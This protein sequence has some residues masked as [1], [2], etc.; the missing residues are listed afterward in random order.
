MCSYILNKLRS[1]KHLPL[2]TMLCLRSGKNSIL[3]SCWKG[4]YQDIPVWFGS[5]S[6]FIVS[7]STG[8]LT[9]TQ[10]HAV[11]ASSHATTTGTLG[12]SSLSWLW[13]PTV[14]CPPE[15]L[16]LSSGCLWTCI[17]CGQRQREKGGKFMSNNRLPDLAQSKLNRVVLNYFPLERFDN[18]V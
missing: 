15:L 12:H 5:K 2:V 16:Q 6:T 9:R 4:A 8:E 13:W 1:L 10:S 17:D 7:P 11:H 14:P 18:T 3:S